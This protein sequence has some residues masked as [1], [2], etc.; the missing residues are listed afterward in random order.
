[1]QVNLIVEFQREKHKLYKS[2]KN[3]DINF[4]KYPSTV[5]IRSNII[6]RYTH[7]EFDKLRAFCAYVPQ[8]TTCLRALNFYVFYVP[9]HASKLYVSTV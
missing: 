7:N 8:I 5:F 4:Y 2:Y 1:M 6:N 3:Y 9:V